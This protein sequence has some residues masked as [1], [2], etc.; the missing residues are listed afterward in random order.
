[1]EDPFPRSCGCEV[2]LRPEPGESAREQGGV[3]AYCWCF[4]FSQT[5]WKREGTGACV[6]QVIRDQ[7]PQDRAGPRRAERLKVD[8]D[9]GE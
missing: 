4:P 5:N 8:E 9:N 2:Q 6:M 3:N 1:M 7:R